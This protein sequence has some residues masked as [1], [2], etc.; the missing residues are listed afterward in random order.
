MG[1]RCGESLRFDR[2]CNHAFLG[3]AS[4][5]D[6]NLCFYPWTNNQKNWTRHKPWTTL[7]KL[8][9]FPR[10]KEDSDH[11]MHGVED[12]LRHVDAHDSRLGRS[13]SSAAYT[14]DKTSGTSP[15]LLLGVAE[16]LSITGS[17]ESSSHRERAT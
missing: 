6:L 9:R 5:L 14:Y 10:H 2:K 16:E 7:K 17:P 15:F 3:E 1:K 4:A 13:K 11:D 12:A 8:K